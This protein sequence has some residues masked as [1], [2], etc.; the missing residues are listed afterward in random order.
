MTVCDNAATHVKGDNSNLKK[1]M[2]SIDIDV[3]TLPKHSPELNPIE[4]IFNVMV[5]RFNSEFNSKKIE[6]D[7]DVL[8]LL[9]NVIDSIRPDVM[10]SCYEKCGHNNFY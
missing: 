10:F 9:T 2:K 1:A 5:Q 4:L 7:Q 6:T 3:M 8:N